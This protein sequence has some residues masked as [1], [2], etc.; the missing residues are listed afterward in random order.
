[1]IIG[2]TGTNGAGKGTVVDYLK[3]KGFT[4]FSVRKFLF[5]EIEKRGLPLDRNSTRLVANE[6]RQAHGPEYVVQSLYESMGQQHGP[7]IIESIRTVG[8]AEFLRSKGA[9]LWAVDADRALRYERTL[10]RWSETDKV[11]YE[12]FCEYEDREMHSREPWDMNVFKVMGMADQ[13][14]DNSSTLENLYQQIE[15]ALKNA[16]V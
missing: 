2:I 4:H 7:A 5:S 6:L 16:G 14:F 10:K 1:M 8:E 3:G 12:Q 9:L 11:S 13:V 15:G